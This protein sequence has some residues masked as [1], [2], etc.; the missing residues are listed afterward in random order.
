MDYKT[1][2]FIVKFQHSLK[3]FVTHPFIGL[4]LIIIVSNCLTNFIVQ[5]QTFDVSANVALIELQ[6][7]IIIEP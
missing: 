1:H 5:W 4:K 7:Y 6:T 3:V 2:Q